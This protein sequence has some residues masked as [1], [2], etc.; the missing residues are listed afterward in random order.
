MM[1]IFSLLGRISKPFLTMANESSLDRLPAASRAQRR[2]FVLL[3]RWSKATKFFLVEAALF[4]LPARRIKVRVLEG[5]SLKRSEAGIRVLCIDSRLDKKNQSFLLFAIRIPEPAPRQGL[6][7]LI[8]SLC[9]MERK[10][11]HF[12]VAFPFESNQMRFPFC[13]KKPRYLVW[14]GEHIF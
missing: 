12:V 6:F 3:V 9:L 4:F 10:Q 8:Q 2:C 11:F 14:K 1:E 7:S 13:S 5:P